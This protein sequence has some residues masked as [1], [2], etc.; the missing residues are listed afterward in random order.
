ME[1]REYTDFGRD[2]IIA[3]YESVGWMNYVQRPDMLE[4]AYGNSL[5]ALG[6][7]E[8]E[9]LVGVIR[10]VG[11]GASIV[12]IQD[13]IVDPGYQRRGIGT[14]LMN[15]VLERYAAVYQIE[16]MTDDTPQT[17]AFYRSLGFRAADEMGCRAFLR[18]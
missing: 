11:D 12:F 6:A 13:I 16:L 17:A 4:K 3:L 8:D 1:I 7:Y 2:E 10:A 15:A 18:M 9:K 5:L 14:A